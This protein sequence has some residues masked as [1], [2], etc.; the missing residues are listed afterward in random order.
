MDGDTHIPLTWKFSPLPSH[1]VTLLRCIIKSI[2]IQY[3]QTGERYTAQADERGLWTL[4]QSCEKERGISF[5]EFAT[6]NNLVQTNTLNPHKSSMRWT[7]HSPNGKYHNHS[8]KYLG[9]VV[10]DNGSNPEVLSR[11][12]QATAALTKLK[13]IWRDNYHIYPARRRSFLSV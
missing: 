1:M 3:M 5:L 13:H 11:I 9:A 10:S 4:L 12:A 6:F 8:F 2:G 7:W